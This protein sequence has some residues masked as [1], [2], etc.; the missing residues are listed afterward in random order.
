[1]LPGY[2][3]RSPALP[4]PASPFQPEGSSAGSPGLGASRLL[5]SHWLRAPGKRSRGSAAGQL[6]GRHLG[7]KFRGRAVGGAE[8]GEVPGVGR[9]GG[10]WASGPGGRGERGGGAAEKEDEAAGVRRPRRA[11][12]PSLHPL[13]SAPRAPG[14]AG[15]R[16]AGPGWGAAPSLA[17][18]HPSS[19]RTPLTATLWR[20]RR[21][22]GPRRCACGARGRRGERPLPCPAPAGAARRQRARR[23]ASERRGPEQGG[24]PVPLVPSQRSA[25]AAGSGAKGRSASPARTQ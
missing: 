19:E 6:G 5:T 15:V 17:G 22:G 25:A 20:R 2:P 16:G 1:M 11:P 13:R 3:F 4:R 14:G 7:G 21:C 23:K 12:P 24:R 8:G 9:A 18:A 10:N